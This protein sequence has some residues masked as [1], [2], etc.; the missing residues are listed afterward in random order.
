MS[1]RSAHHAT[2]VT[3][4]PYAA[5][6]PRVFAAWVQVAANIAL[7]RRGSIEVRPIKELKR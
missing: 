1:K 2:F 7:A 6:S 4:R 3:E 5:S